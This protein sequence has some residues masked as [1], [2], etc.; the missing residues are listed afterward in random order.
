MDSR[1]VWT[2]EFDE[3]LAQ[4]TVQLRVLHRYAERAVESGVVDE[5]LIK[6]VRLVNEAEAK[7]D[8]L[9]MQII[10]KVEA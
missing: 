6:S 9:R 4:V 5:G 10:G 7:L 1:S 2:K 8:G 3:A